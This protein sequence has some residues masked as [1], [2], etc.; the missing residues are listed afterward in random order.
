M[1]IPKTF[2]ICPGTQFLV[3]LLKHNRFNIKTYNI[4]NKNT[5]LMYDLDYSFIVKDDLIYSSYKQ[6]EQTLEQILQR[7][8]DGE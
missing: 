2:F 7:K 5:Y 1:I 4:K 6:N 8:Y 3:K